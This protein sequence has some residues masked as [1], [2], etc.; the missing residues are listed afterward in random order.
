MSKIALSY[1]V[2]KAAGKQPFEFMAYLRGC[3]YNARMNTLIYPNCKTVIHIDI[4]LLNEY[5]EYFNDLIQLFNAEL[6]IYYSEQP[7]LCRGMLRRINPQLFEKYDIIFSRDLDSVTTYREAQCVQRFIS[8]G[9]LFHSI[10]D[11]VAHSLP[12]MGGMIGIKKEGWQKYF[13]NI[14]TLNDLVNGYDLSVHGSDQAL[15]MSKIFPFIE[16]EITSDNLQKQE[17][18]HLALQNVRSELWESNLIIR[19]IG[20]AGINELECLRFFLRHEKNEY[21]AF[22][23]KHSSIL[24]WGAY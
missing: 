20:S 8:S 14:K 23:K 12:M 6:Y 4:D 5:S 2:F 7:Q 24:Y 10:M 19:H 11:N 16:S 22:E 3:Y 21:S 1:S 9:S 15:L 17:P 18:N 13:S